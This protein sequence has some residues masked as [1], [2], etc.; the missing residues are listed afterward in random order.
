VL[1]K[2]ITVFNLN[3]GMAAELETLLKSAVNDTA[4]WPN[5]RRVY[6]FGQLDP[7]KCALLCRA[8]HL[9]WWMPMT[10]RVVRGDI[11]ELK[12]LHAAYTKDMGQGV[13][14]DFSPMLSWVM[15]PTEIAPGVPTKRSPD[16]IRQ[17]LK[18]GGDPNYSDGKWLEYAL[19]KHEADCIKPLLEHGAASSTVQRVMEALQREQNFTQLGRV[20]EAL[21]RT[22]HIK[23]DAETVMEAKYIPDAKGTSVFKTLFNFS[24]RRVHEIYESGQ[25]AQATMQGIPFSDYDAEALVDARERLI[26]LGGT[27]RELADVLEKPKPAKPGLRPENG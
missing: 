14:V 15:N 27:P 22:S 4:Q 17:M 16:V 18:W 21:A 23:I 25:G 19:R 3:I 5:D 8:G 26:R 11:E 12:Q 24:A 7:D 1:L 6:T 20:Q 10:G 9:P 2:D 13:K